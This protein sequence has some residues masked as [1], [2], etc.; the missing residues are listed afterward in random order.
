[1]LVISHKDPSISFEIQE[2]QDW[3]GSLA[4]NNSGL[5]RRSM[6]RTTNHLPHFLHLCVLTVDKWQVK[7]K[8][9]GSEAMPS[10]LLNDLLASK[11]KSSCNYDVPL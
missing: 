2:K 4:R 11:T 5:T 9:P 8:T 3:D 6:P 1:M 7:M 10:S